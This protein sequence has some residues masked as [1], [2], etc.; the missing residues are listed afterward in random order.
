MPIRAGL[1][2]RVS[3]HDRISCDLGQRPLPVLGVAIVGAGVGVGCGHEDV[4]AGN[5]GALL[6]GRPDL[7]H[8]LG[9]QVAEFDRDHRPGAI[10]VFD[11]EGARKQ[12]VMD[13]SGADVTAAVAHQFAAQL[14][15]DIRATEAGA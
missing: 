3:L 4:G 13:A 7:S 9:E 5:A 8:R 15:G 12:R 10:A 11:D 2:R 6:H 1:P 14:G